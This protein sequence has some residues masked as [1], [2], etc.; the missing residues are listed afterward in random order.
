LSITN[1]CRV[2]IRRDNYTDI[3]EDFVEI[4]PGTFVIITRGIDYVLHCP[5]EPERRH[6]LDTGVYKLALRTGCRISGPGWTLMGIRQFN[7]TAAIHLPT[8]DVPPINISVNLPQKVIHHYLNH[9]KWAGFHEIKDVKFLTELPENDLGSVINWG[10]HPGHISWTTAILVMLI[11]AVLIA[12]CFV[13]YREG[14]LKWPWCKYGKSIKAKLQ[15]PETSE[16]TMKANPEQNE[17]PSTTS[18]LYPDVSPAFRELLR[19]DV[20]PAPVLEAKLR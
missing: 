4:L 11:I 7:S 19:G 13:L 17:V 16:V 3:S 2:T 9:P 5:S 6:T 12:I 15:G 18:R 8:I 14:I 10:T 1:S 20:T